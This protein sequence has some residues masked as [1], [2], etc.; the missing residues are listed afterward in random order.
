MTKKN[1]PADYY[2][3][4]LVELV[5]EHLKEYPM[6]SV[7]FFANQIIENATISYE[8]DGFFTV[9]WHK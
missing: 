6:E 8:G 2:L 7:S 5:A 1:K 9:E 3:D 4:D